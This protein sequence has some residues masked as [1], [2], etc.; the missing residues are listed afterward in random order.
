V[1]FFSFRLLCFSPLFKRFAMRGIPQK[2]PGDLPGQLWGS[3]L[4]GGA[5]CC[6]FG[7]PFWTH[8]GTL[9]V[10]VV[11]P[12]APQDSF[13][14][15]WSFLVTFLD[16]FWHPWG[17]GAPPGRNRGLPRGPFAALLWVPGAKTM[18]K[19]VKSSDLSIL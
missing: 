13:G 8:F 2:A 5:I 1:Q 14:A 19:V 16:T 11:T 7:S 4:P 9:G 3:W 12:G 6:H 10:K 18:A 15:G 17:Q